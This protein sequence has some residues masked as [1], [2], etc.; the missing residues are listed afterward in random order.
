MQFEQ[1]LYMIIKIL[2][3]YFRYPQIFLRIRHL[4]FRKFIAAGLC[5]LKFVDLT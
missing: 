1:Q 4:L 5:R 3:H 2:S